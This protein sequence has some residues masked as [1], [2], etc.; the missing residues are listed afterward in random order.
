MSVLPVFN[1]T[2]TDLLPS[3]QTAP[4]ETDRAVDFGRELKDADARLDRPQ[5]SDD[6]PKAKTQTET[7][8]A[9]DTSDASTTPEKADPVRENKQTDRKEDAPAET[10][11]AADQADAAADEAPVE[12]ASSIPVEG[13]QP[14]TDAST[15][16]ASNNQLVEQVLAVGGESSNQ[17]GQA[18]ST[19]ALNTTQATEQ[20][21]AANNATAQA[22][23]DQASS[24]VPGVLQ[25]QP[26]KAAQPQQ[27]GAPNQNE[28]SATAQR[29]AVV[30]EAR[31]DT[32][33]Q[34][35]GEE[36]GQQH[37]ALKRDAG[38]Q[39][40]APTSQAPAPSFTAT[41]APV[42]A[43]STSSQTFTATDTAAP[44]TTGTSQ[45]GPAVTTQ[46]TDN[47]QLNTAR[48]SRGLQNAVNLKGGAVTLR[49]TPPEMGTVRIQLQIQ[50]GTVN[51][52]FHA[53]TESTR[54]M[55][56]QQ[57]AHLRSALES[58]GLNVERLGVQTMH[59]TSGSNLQ[60]ES[61][62]DREGQANEGRSRGGFSQQGNRQGQPS[63]TSEQQAFEQELTH[64]A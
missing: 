62:G 12:T 49:L 23:T 4:A 19:A 26:D 7:E 50:N 37:S 51:A 11:G 33:G 55:L 41:S 61:Q 47:T 60:H 18:S 28:P 38:P 20:A 24:T 45:T 27:A 53:E 22:A 48:I 17:A 15:T 52:Q 44:A 21:A 16:A 2:V 34:P 46:D 36:T 43:G 5:S 58:Q 56:N 63:D 39:V 40:A 9:R 8:A 6:Q 14:T 25:P 10:T 31:Q 13:T 29:I 42:D 1:Q 3:R 57:M 54:T 30:A 32:G 35:S 59:N 64:A